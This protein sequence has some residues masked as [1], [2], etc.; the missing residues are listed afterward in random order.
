MNTNPTFNHQHEPAPEPLPVPPE[1]LPDG[2]LESIFEE[3]YEL[4]EDRS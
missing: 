1:P 4:D 2:H 3:L